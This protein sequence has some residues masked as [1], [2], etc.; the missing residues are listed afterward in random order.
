MTTIDELVYLLEGAFS[1]AG[2]A[3]TDESQALLVNI[4]SVDEQM[5]R[6]LP[7][8]GARS[9]E[10]IVLHVGACTI[11]YDEYAF[12]AGALTWDDRSWLPW[13]EGDAPMGA[14]IEWLKEVHARFVE[15]VRELR[16]EDLAT[17]R[18]TNWGQ[19]RETR[20]L[21]STIAQHDVYHA[22]EVNHLRS[23]LAVED[24]WR[25]G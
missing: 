12:G 13:S 6:A 21:I 11:M 1:G 9:V 15:H 19:L 8:G 25:W 22:G 10:S 7:L 24:R 23:I 17:P 14:T 5:W 4:S 20:W 18:S 3:E 2:S 16:D